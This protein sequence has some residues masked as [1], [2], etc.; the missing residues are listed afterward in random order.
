M[1]QVKK[2]LLVTALLT[3]AAGAQAEILTWKVGSP[4]A[5]SVVATFNIDDSTFTL[6][7]SGA[8][9]NYAYFSSCPWYSLKDKIK[10]VIIGDGVTTI[11]DRAFDGCSGLTSVTIPNS[12]T[13]IG[14]SAF[15]YCS[16]LTSVTIPNSV[17]TIGDYAFSYCSGLTSVRIGSSVTM[18]GYRAFRSCTGLASIDVDVANSRYSSIDGILYNKVQD[19]LLF[20]PQGKTGDVD[21]PTSVTMIGGSAFY[22]CT[23]LT[24]VAIPNSVITI[25]D[26][27]F[28]ECL[29]LTSVAIPNSVITIGDEAFNACIGLISV[30]IGAS[31]TTIG[32]SAFSDCLGLTS[33]TIPNSVTTIGGYAF[34]YCSG[35]TSVIIGT[36]VTII[37]QAA[38]LNCTSLASVTVPNSV[39]TIENSAFR[40]CSGL[41]S[42]TIPNSV[43]TIG[44]SAFSRCTGLTLVTIGSGVRTIGDGA[45]SYCD[46]LISVKCL[47]IAPPAINSDNFPVPTDILYVP[48][49][50][51]TAYQNSTW[52]TLFG[53]IL[54]LAPEVETEVVTTGTSVTIGWEP[55]ANTAE[56]VLIIYQNG[57]EVARVSFDADG[58]IRTKTAG[59]SAGS[60]TYNL[61]D[62]SEGTTYTYTLTAY[63][64]SR[65]I[66]GEKEGVF[67]TLGESVTTEHLQA[68][69]ATIIMKVF[70]NPT[71]N[72]IT[73][74]PTLP[75]GNIDIYNTVGLRVGTYRTTAEQTVIN[76]Q[77]FPAG[78]YFIKH[79]GK[80]VKVVKR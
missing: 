35:L 34:S 66:V 58:N 29:G 37:G 6:S 69:A 56:Y 30:T 3:L 75:G 17:T 54:P 16:G 64:A 73:I 15:S 42:V 24:S 74:S 52:G 76:M 39:T 62:L 48:A 28:N 63:D 70:P 26:R 31:V 8:M 19:T 45:F 57:V 65:I 59:K 2:I 55:V 43:T 40:N 33:V 23:S 21:I 38:F 60:L 25:G 5:N 68:D 50:S 1:K 36:S 49:I 77:N 80:T 51:V 78:I 22:R 20:C 10:M 46:N 9:Q 44:A 12:V 61:T 11:G 67:T 32:N 53:I 79:G 41:T 47:N 7:G 18:I 27:A 14:G 4:I 71:S 13:T 72:E